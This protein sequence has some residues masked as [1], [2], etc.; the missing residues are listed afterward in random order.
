MHFTGILL[1][2]PICHI[3]VGTCPGVAGTATYATAT[4]LLKPAQVAA[5]AAAIAVAANAV[6]QTLVA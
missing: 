1:T 2:G 4:E 5:A 6:N 3:N